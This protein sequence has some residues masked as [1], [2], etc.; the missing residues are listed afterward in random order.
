MGDTHPDLSN[1]G[2][3]VECNINL[4]SQVFFYGSCGRSNMGH[5]IFSPGPKGDMTCGQ[6]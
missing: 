2:N 1:V 6:I 5:V 3:H 4:T